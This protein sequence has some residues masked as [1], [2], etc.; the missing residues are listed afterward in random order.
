MRNKALTR[1]ASDLG[2]AL[3]AP[4]GAEQTWSFPGSP[5]HHRDEI[6][7][8]NTLLDDVLQ[9][10]PI[11]RSRIMASGFSMGGSMVW[12]LACRMSDRF[13]GFAPI[14][15]GYWDP[16]PENCDGPVPNLI[17]VH[18][19]AD[20]TVPI[21]GRPIGTFYRQGDI[22][23]GMDKWVRIGRCANET[24]VHLQDGRLTCERRR[25]CTGALIELCLH[26]G[27]HSLRT[28]WVTRAWQ[29]LAARLDWPGAPPGNSILQ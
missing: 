7:F 8:F 25:S 15:G 29:A 16:A 17:H 19:T 3:I 5:S 27:G 4:Q 28:E 12:H 26:P 9:R 13:A 6:A 23:N 22:I 11:D 18:G 24:P 14:A 10:F 1:A 2:V 21:E 20:R